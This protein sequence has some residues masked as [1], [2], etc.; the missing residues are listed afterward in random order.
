MI[1]AK[2]PARENHANGGSGRREKEYRVI[3]T[4]KPVIVRSSGFFHLGRTA[5]YHIT[6]TWM[7]SLSDGT[8]LTSLITSES[9]ITAAG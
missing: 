5:L 9:C 4:K 1:A 3:S 8:G 7:A 2:A 6:S